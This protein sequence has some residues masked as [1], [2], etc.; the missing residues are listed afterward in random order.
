MDSLPLEILYLILDPFNFEYV[1][2]KTMPHYRCLRLVNRMF[3][4]IITP[5]I[6]NRLC[7]QSNECSLDR[8]KSIA[9]QP[10]LSQLVKRYTYRFVPHGREWTLLLCSSR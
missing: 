1:T 2:G 6:F 7:I 3:C 9:Q 10:E 5:N 4:A 8:L